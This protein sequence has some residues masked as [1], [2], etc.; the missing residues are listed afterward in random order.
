MASSHTTTTAGQLGPT[1][2]TIYCTTYG[3]D[4]YRSFGNFPGDKGY[5]AAEFRERF[6]GGVEGAGDMGSEHGRFS[7]YRVLQELTTSWCPEREEHGYLL[8]PLFKC[9]TSPRVVTAHCWT[10]VDVIE[11]MNKPTGALH[12]SQFRGHVV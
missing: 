4:F 10:A 6:G 8:T 7:N 3:L 2:G 1:T 12:A 9:T 11:H 5:S